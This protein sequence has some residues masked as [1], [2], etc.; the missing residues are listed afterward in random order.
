MY[1]IATL[2]KIS[3]VGLKQLPGGYI[4]VENASEADGI[5][6]RSQDMHEMELGDKLKAIARAGAG[7][8]NIPLDKCAERGIVVFNTPGANANAVKELVLC[9]LL[10]AARNVPSALSW[11]A[12]LKEDVSK[13][14]EKGKSQFTGSEILGKTLG[15]VGL[16]AIGRK[17]AASAKA[18]GMEIVGYDPYYV[19]GGEGISVY[20][21]LGEMLSLCDYVTLHLPAN[22]STKGMMNAELFDAMK[23]G[24]VLLNFSRDKLVNELDLAAAM[25]SG[26]VAKYVTDFPNDNMVGRENV[27]LLPH[28]GASTAEAEDN[29]AVMAVDEIRSYFENGNI[30]NSVNFPRLD[31][32]ELGSGIRVAVMIKDVADPALSVMEMLSAA[33]IKYSRV[34][35][36]RREDGISYVL[37][38]ITQES[39]PSLLFYGEEGAKIISYR[40]IEK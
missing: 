19:S 6:V 5:L 30:I 22:D 7:V 32:G 1:K 2:N 26:K 10:L 28:L 39:I 16:G 4:L 29:C 20:S 27:I 18:L 8:N 17:V 35:A 31:M 12:G 38:E 21:D 33:K 14:V 11:A 9:G 15:V 40:A 23:D 37:A 24:T 13:T 36:S 34:M 3:P 25:E